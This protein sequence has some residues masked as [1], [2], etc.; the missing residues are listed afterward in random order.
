VCD[1]PVSE[2]PRSI[3][4]PHL[5]ALEAKLEKARSDET[6]ARKV[7]EEKRDALA[8]A[9][10]RAREAQR[11]L[12]KRLANLGKHGQTLRAPNN[13]WTPKSEH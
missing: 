7:V 4:T 13:N 9:E 8:K 6:A 3:P 11:A 10:T 5:E 1:R 12:K 2:R